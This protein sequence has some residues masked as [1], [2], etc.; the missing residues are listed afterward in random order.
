MSVAG[1]ALLADVP[2]STHLG[3]PAGELRSPVC[4]CAGGTVAISPLSR[5]RLVPKIATT[6]E[7]ETHS[8]SG[9]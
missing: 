1:I 3:S 7:H 4:H 9:E 2:A 8:C 5:G 6:Q